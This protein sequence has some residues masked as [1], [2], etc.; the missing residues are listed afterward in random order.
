M[1]PAERNVQRVT[2]LELR[3][4]RMAQRLGE[5]RKAGEV[6]IRELHQ[7]HGGAGRRE[8][9]RRNVEI[10]DLVGRKQREAAAPG[11]YAG[12][13]VG[14]V[15]VGIDLDRIADPDARL[16]ACIQQWHTVRAGKAR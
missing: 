15:E 11:R 14:E 16:D 1:P 12:D 10:L 13:V 2:R 9:E 6:G 7:A 4:L 3:L 8:V 5:T